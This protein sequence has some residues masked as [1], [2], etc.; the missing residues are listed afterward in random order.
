MLDS[1]HRAATFGHHR[2]LEIGGGVLSLV[3]LAEQIRQTTVNQITVCQTCYGA[4]W[5]YICAS[6]ATYVVANLSGVYALYQCRKVIYVGQSDDIRTRLLVHS[7]RFAFTGIKISVTK[8]RGT[9]L[10][11]EARLLYRL[12]PKRNAT[13]PVRLP[14]RPL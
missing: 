4:D 2:A 1:P 3:P 9:R 6:Q 11:R 7:R 5:H 12:R 10:F 13:M 8:D 14:R